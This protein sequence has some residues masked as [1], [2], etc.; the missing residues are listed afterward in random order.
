MIREVTSEMANQDTKQDRTYTMR[1]IKKIDMDLVKAYLDGF[2]VLGYG[3]KL[4]DM[5][6][7]SICAIFL[8]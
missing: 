1:T 7:L 8:F 6:H 5:N 4:N 2:P 3:E